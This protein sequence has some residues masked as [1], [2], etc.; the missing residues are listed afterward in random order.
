L[1]DNFSMYYNK[2]I[3]R[4]RLIKFWIFFGGNYSYRFNY[5]FLNTFY[6][7][8]FF[9]NLKYLFSSLKRVLPL[10]LN[11]SNLNGRFLFVSENWLFCKSCYDKTYLSFIKNLIIKKSGGMFSNFSFF[12]YQF[13]KGLDFKINPVLLVFFSFKEK[14]FLVKEAKKKTCQ[15]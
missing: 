14:F 13:L 9:F 12:S 7:K 8:C 15:S 5:K 3:K 11:I 2:L 4:N 1:I 10:F 6:D